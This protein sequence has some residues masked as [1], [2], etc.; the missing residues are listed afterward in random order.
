MSRILTKEIPR[1]LFLAAVFFLICAPNSF[2][3]E[4]LTG[5]PLVVLDPGHDREAPGLVSGTGQQEAAATFALARKLS[6]LLSASCR[7]RLTR[8]AETKASDV[9]RAAFANHEKADLYLSLHLHDGQTGQPVIYYFSLPE[10]SDGDTWQTRA[11]RNQ[12]ESKQFAGDL[13]DALKTEVAGSRPLVLSGPILPLEGLNMP[14]ILVEPFAI[15][16]VPEGLD[17]M[18]AFLDGQAQDIAAGILAFLAKRPS[19]S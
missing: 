4:I 13:A 2:A 10:K 16:Q 8:T 17:Q 18:D 11:L 15:S 6:G 12:A 3:A 7:I 14:G 19:G 5:Q 1:L 9:E